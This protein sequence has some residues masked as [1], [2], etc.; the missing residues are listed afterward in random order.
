MSRRN[1][2]KWKAVRI[3]DEERLTAGLTDHRAPAWSPDGRFVAFAAGEGR[4]ASW[5]IADRRGRVARVLPGPAC[6]GATFRADG[7]LAFGRRAGEA[8]ELWLAQPALPAVRLA[9]GDGL[10]YRDPAFSPDGALLAFACAEDASAPARLWLLEVESGARHPLPSASDRS[11]GHPVFA[12]E[13]GEL[14]FDGIEG[15]DE[16][17]FALALANHAVARI[18]D[19]RTKSRHPA[20]ISRELLVVERL[21]EHGSSLA[22]IDRHGRERALCEAAEERREP[23]VRVGRSGKVRLAFSQAGIEDGLRRWDVAV[24]RIKGLSLESSGEPDEPEATHESAPTEA[25]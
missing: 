14:F 5:V 13:G 11:D 17:V 23:T 15:A 1:G 24:G 18:S 16:G 10:T 4:D 7:A 21:G 6:G 8:C 20:P 22:L 19:P 9:G 25:A 3:E 2:V 12:P